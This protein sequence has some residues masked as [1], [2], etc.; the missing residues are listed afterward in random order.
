MAKKEFRFL[1]S[2]QLKKSKHRKKRTLLHSARYGS[3]FLA[4][5][6]KKCN[7]YDFFSND[8]DFLSHNSDFYLIILTF[9]LKILTLSHNSDF[10]LRIQTFI[11]LFLEF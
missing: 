1:N 4:Q 8:S 5:N 6:N 2:L 9:Y 7:F 11:S 3:L 10:Y